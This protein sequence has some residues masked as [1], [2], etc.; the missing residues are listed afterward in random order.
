[1]ARE[2]GVTSEQGQAATEHG[3]YHGPTI[4]IHIPIDEQG[5]R[6][7]ISVPL[8]ILWDP[9]KVILRIGG[10]Q[11]MALMRFAVAILTYLQAEQVPNLSIAFLEFWNTVVQRLTI[12]D[13]TWEHQEDLVTVLTYSLLQHKQ[14]TY[15]QAA[16]IAS[17]LLEVDHPISPDA[18]RLRLNRWAKKHNL[19][20][21]T[22][23]RGRPRIKKTDV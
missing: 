16:E 7:P 22:G 12:P 9:Y 15:V 21:L 4:S 11:T 19:S 17:A 14:I 23:K 13:R 18:W 5:R 1:M 2:D 20:P 8:P 10:D 6:I 3:Q